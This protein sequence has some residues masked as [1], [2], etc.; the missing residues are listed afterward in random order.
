MILDIRGLFKLMKLHSIHNCFDDARNYQHTKVLNV[1]IYPIG[2]VSGNSLTSIT[3]IV[4][5]IY[6]WKYVILHQHL[7]I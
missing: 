5:H 1:T 7:Y 4:D 2:R 6:L 3:V